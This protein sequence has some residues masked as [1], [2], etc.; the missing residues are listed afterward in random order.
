MS[1]GDPQKT[2]CVITFSGK[3]EDWN[4]WSKMF[5][6]METARGLREVLHPSKPEE[7]QDKK[8]NE[9]VYSDLLLACQEDVVFGVIDESTSKEFPDGDARLAWTS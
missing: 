4:R 6:A 7:K 3:D 5:L 9:K 1:S 8:A 2:I